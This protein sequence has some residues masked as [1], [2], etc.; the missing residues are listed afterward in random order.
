MTVYTITVIDTVGDP[1]LGIRRTP[2]IFSNLKDA[3]DAV[4]NNDYDLSEDNYY[5]YAVIEETLLNVVRPDLL[6]PTH[7]MWFKFNTV[8]QE[9]EMCRLEQ[10]PKQLRNLSGFGIG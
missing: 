2:A 6:A 7:K 10:I 1:V 8:L 5:Q 4:R 3:V 9:F